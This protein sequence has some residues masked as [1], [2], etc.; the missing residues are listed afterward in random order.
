MIVGA[1]RNMWWTTT[2]IRTTFSRQV[3]RCGE[4]KGQ[5]H[6]IGL[7]N[8]LTSYTRLSKTEGQFF[9]S[10]IN[11]IKLFRTVC[12]NVLQLLVASMSV[13]QQKVIG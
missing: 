7:F 11:G 5:Y 1:M 10:Q 2:M 9:W 6:E 12:Q 13:F 8:A 3:A 4:L